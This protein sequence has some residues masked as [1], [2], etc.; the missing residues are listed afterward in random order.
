MRSRTILNRRPTALATKDIIK[1]TQDEA[2]DTIRLEFK[3]KL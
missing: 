2:Y 3:L 1:L